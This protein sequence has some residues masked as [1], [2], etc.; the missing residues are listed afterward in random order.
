M[1]I[2]EEFTLQQGKADRHTNS[3]ASC[4]YFKLDVSH[5]PG[6]KWYKVLVTSS[7]SNSKIYLITGDGNT[8][9]QT[10]WRVDDSFLYVAYRVFSRLF[11][12]SFI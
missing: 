10:S 1:E 2:I 9:K 11:G 6:L 12:F 5:F 4:A 8:E 7:Q 3:M